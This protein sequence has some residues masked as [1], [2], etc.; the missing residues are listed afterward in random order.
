MLHILSP[1]ALDILIDLDEMGGK[2]AM[3]HKRSGKT[4]RMKHYHCRNTGFNAAWYDT[5]IRRK[6]MSRAMLEYG[7]S[8]F[9]WQM[10]KKGA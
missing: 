4:E 5:G 3:F 9:E 8:A 6:R 1:A 10:E 2:C 7:R